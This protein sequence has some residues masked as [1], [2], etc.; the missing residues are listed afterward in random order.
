MRRAGIADPRDRAPE[1]KQ[2]E[3]HAGQGRLV[4]VRQERGAD[5]RAGEE[6]IAG[7]GGP[8]ARGSAPGLQTN[9]SGR[10][11]RTLHGGSLERF[12]GR[13]MPL[14]FLA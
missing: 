7:L 12:L 3:R 4:G 6:E 13:P 14:P 11:E 9:T 1:E 2:D 10:S 5:C 8:H